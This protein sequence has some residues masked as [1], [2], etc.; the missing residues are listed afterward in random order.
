M[1]NPS[2]I[3][4][5]IAEIAITLAG[6]TGLIAVFRPHRPWSG[7]EVTRLQTIV[8]ACFACMSAA[9]LP[10]ALA[11]F[12]EDPRI[13]WGLPLAAF[14]VMQ[15]GILAYLYL[16]YRQR[17]FRPSG[18][19]SRVVLGADT[20]VSLVF[21]LAAFGVLLEPTAGLLVLACTWGVAFP[22]VGFV[23]TFVVVTRGSTGH[24]Q[25]QN[26]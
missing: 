1:L 6:F 18:V 15:I 20:L 25:L 22:A 21:L 11:G 7:Q 8:A 17:T 23:L 12:S 16:R 5:T 14:A 9:L 10:F 19:V 4:G 13:V 3:L 24:D 26:Q 2:D